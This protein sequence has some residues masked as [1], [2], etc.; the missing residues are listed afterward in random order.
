MWKLRFLTERKGGK[1]P[2]FQGVKGS[3]LI[4]ACRWQ[5]AVGSWKSTAKDKTRVIC[6]G[7][8]F[9]VAR[10][11]IKKGIR[12]AVLG[13]RTTRTRPLRLQTKKY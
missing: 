3:R 2:R 13:T 8:G 4:T 7:E 11:K 9:E 1:V 6:K 5:L 10:K 12:Y